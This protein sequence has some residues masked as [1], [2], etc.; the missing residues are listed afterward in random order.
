MKDDA[1]ISPCKAYRYWLSRDLASELS[2]SK[3][4]EKSA[5]LFV[6]LNPST[7]NAEIDDPTIRRCR[8]FAKRWKCNGLIVANLYAL[9]ATDPKQL[10]KSDD[11]VG[12]DNDYW[13]R[14][15]SSQYLDVICGWGDNAKKDR[16][17]TFKLMMDKIGARLWCL[18]MTRSGAPMHPLYI[19]SDQPLIKWESSS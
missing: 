6:M 18:G 12:K 9:R 11:P 3:L 19:K 15:L 13:L 1:L 10:W 16:V 8:G 14:K 4:A 2:A 17:E 5:A 7:A